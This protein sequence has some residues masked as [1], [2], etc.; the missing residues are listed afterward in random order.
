MCFKNAKWTVPGNVTSLN[1]LIYPRF[2]PT[3]CIPSLTPHMWGEAHA[4]NGRGP[5]PHVRGG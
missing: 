5:S 2:G 4:L 1:V 3:T